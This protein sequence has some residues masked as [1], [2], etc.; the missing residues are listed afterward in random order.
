MPLNKSCSLDAYKANVKELI[1]SGRKIDQAVAIA[2][3]TLKSSCGVKSKE[4][5]APGKIVGEAMR[6]PRIREM[7]S[8]LK[9]FGRVSFDNGYDTFDDVLDHFEDF[10]ISL[11]IGKNE[12]KV[13]EDF[14]RQNESAF[15]KDQ[16]AYWSSIAKQC[17]YVSECLRMYSIALENELPG[18]GESF[19]K[20]AIQLANLERWIP[21]HE[22]L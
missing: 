17:N 11:R 15:A 10:R 13:L 21:I 6:F 8:S 3:R 14:K 20:R 19:Q 4:R 5:M 16:E 7:A 12:L 1:E 18:V 2:I 22:V 9:T